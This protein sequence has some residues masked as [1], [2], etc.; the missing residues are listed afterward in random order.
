MA[1]AAEDDEQMSLTQWKA[2][3]VVE[4]YADAKQRDNSMDSQKAGKGKKKKTV[5]GKIAS[6]KTTSGGGDHKTSIV[7][8]RVDASEMFGWTK[9][10]SGQGFA[11][12]ANFT[13][14]Y[15]DTYQHL[16]DTQI[17]AYH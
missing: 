1:G 3:D 5:M 7:L 13:K 9:Q 14:T 12:S 15:H 10:S 16:G 17:S 2:G 6:I 11:S 8:Q 4:D